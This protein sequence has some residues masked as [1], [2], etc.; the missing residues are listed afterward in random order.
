MTARLITIP[1][2]EDAGERF[3][4][5]PSVGCRIVC[6]HTAMMHGHGGGRGTGPEHPALLLD[7]LN[8]W[9]QENRC[10]DARPAVY[11][12]L[13]WGDHVPKGGPR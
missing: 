1:H 8:G 4:M 13:G 9:R 11:R 12:A 2:P 7:L 10:C 6:E 5:R 3:P